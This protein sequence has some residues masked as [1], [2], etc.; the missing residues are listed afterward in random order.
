M[1]HSRIV[2]RKVANNAI[3]IDTWG[4]VAMAY[5][6]EPRFSEITRYYRDISNKQIPI[7]TSD[8][9]LDEFISTIFSRENFNYANRFVEAVLE[10]GDGGRLHIERVSSDRFSAAWELR[11]RYHDKPPISFTDLTSMVIM[12]ELSIQQVLTA[13]AHF[14]HV[15]MGFVQVP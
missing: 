8:Y 15:G 5:R 9:V 4:W 10:A 7:H 13:D 2:E 14:T 3:F 11:K 1:A 12:S 6:Q